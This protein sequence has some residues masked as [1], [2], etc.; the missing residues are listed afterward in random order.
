MRCG[1][2]ITNG[3]TP[4]LDKGMYKTLRSGLSWWLSLVALTALLFSAP[5]A[6]LDLFAGENFSRTVRAATLGVGAITS[7]SI[8][9]VLFGD[10]N[11]TR[12]FAAAIVLFLVFAWVTNAV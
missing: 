11:S 6:M 5:F 9:A 3:K 1:A 4:K 10:R 7:L 8:A 12:V 2:A